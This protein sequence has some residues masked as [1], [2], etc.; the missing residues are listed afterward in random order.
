MQT[1]SDTVRQVHPLAAKGGVRGVL[2]LEALALLLA[3]LALYARIDGDW[4]LFVELFLLPDASLAA[5]LFGSRTGA[6]AYNAAHST[7][8]PLAL[9]AFAATSGAPWA[10][11]VTLI[12]IAHVG[13]DRALG[14]GLKYASGFADTHLGRIGRKSSR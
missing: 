4:L 3:A 9:G 8:G 10:L 12:W 11:A 2:R 14:Y 1:A 5:Y 7:L 13:F 6:L